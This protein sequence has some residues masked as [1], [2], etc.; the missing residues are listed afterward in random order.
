MRANQIF[1]VFVLCCVSL[2]SHAANSRKI[3][4]QDAAAY[5]PTAA[6]P[7]GAA[8]AAR[9]AAQC[10]G[11]VQR[12]Y[13]CA[14]HVTGEYNK[15]QAA[16]EE[17]R[18]KEAEEKKQQAQQALQQALGALG[19]GGGGKGGDKGGGQGG[20]QGGGGGG[21]QG[22]GGA[23]GGGS[24]GGG[25]P[26]GNSAE[27]SP[28]SS[29][30]AGDSGSSESA[31]KPPKKSKEDSSKV[32]APACP[33]DRRG[34]RGKMLSLG[35]SKAGAVTEKGESIV[36][37]SKGT[38]IYAPGLGQVANKKSENGECSFEM[39]D[40]DCPRGSGKCRARILIKGECPGVV[41]DG[42]TLNACTSLGTSEA[43]DSYLQVGKMPDSIDLSF[44]ADSAET[45]EI[46]R[47]Q[48][49]AG[50]LYKRGGRH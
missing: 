45:A 28:Q 29:R 1:S 11:P 44:K 37:Y 20:Q 22:G 16:L 36:P 41:Q 12:G 47:G 7:V 14:S 13:D 15:E 34:P 43:G 17:K 26:A 50:F 6:A 25:G 4:R 21:S 38:P 18:K 42:A 46:A 32:S 48:G 27:A 2:S 40:M 31:G 3:K 35:E 49:P 19:G 30:P 23:G 10:G 39:N 5:T 9:I 8:L 24:Q 33:Q